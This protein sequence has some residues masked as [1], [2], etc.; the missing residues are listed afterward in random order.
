MLWIVPITCVFWLGD[1]NS[2]KKS[3]QKSWL[4]PDYQNREGDYIKLKALVLLGPTSAPPM[5]VVGVGAR[6]APHKTAAHTKSMAQ[7]KTGAM[8][9][10]V[11]APVWGEGVGR[12]LGAAHPTPLRRFRGQGGPTVSASIADYASGSNNPDSWLR[13]SHSGSG[14]IWL[15][16][17]CPASPNPCIHPSAAGNQSSGS[18]PS[19][20][21]CIPCAKDT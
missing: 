1:G 4:H 20:G 2:V 9:G 18:G 19:L 16:V 7:G 15:C 6:A 11:V 13:S 10:V 14:S 8:Q 3:L 17:G 21:Q 12:Q 5:L